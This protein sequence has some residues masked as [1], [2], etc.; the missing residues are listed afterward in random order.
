MKKLE[1][2][3]QTHWV[4]FRNNTII[5]INIKCVQI[6]NKAFDEA[7]DETCEGI[8]ELNESQWEQMKKLIERKVER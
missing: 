4:K 1:M 2:I 5:K 7:N 3:K 6:D 8:I